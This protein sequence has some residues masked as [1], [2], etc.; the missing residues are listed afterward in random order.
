MQSSKPAES[1]RRLIG[2]ALALLLLS[3]CQKS[4]EDIIAEHR[5]AVEA[6]FAKIKALDAAARDAA[7]VA[8]D[9]IDLG[10]AKVVLD[11][12]NTNALFIRQ[13]NLADPLNAT[14]DGTGSTHAGNVKVCGEAL[15]GDFIG[16]PGGAELFLKD[17][18]RAEYVFV[19]RTRSDQAAELVGS[20][21]FNPGMYEG[22]VLLFRL[23]DGA[24]LGGFAVNAKS[25]DE[26]SVALDE[27]GNAIDPI[28]RLNSDM[29]AEV[30][31]EIDTKL[32][33]LVPGSLRD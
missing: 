21:T 1:M 14:S 24:L 18:A 20:D 13:D 22:D 15:R 29:T 26:V 4:L 23:S 27:S 12:E 16:H 11:G 28:G 7:P 33:A 5:P 2:V 8:E 19:Q 25:S 32:R 3:G 30:F 6:V 10:G 17:C 9:R 31:S